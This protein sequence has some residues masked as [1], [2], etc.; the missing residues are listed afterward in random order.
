M[1]SHSDSTT[2][3]LTPARALWSGIAAILSGA[4]LIAG[5]ALTW[6]T[7]DTGD[8][9]AIVEMVRFYGD[10]GNRT[11]SETA[12]VM[13][14]ASAL[15]F[16]CFLPELVR[17]AGRRAWL[18]VAGGTVFTVCLMLA[19]ITGNVYA[20]TANHSAV[21]LVTPETSRTAILLMDV[22]Y[23]GLTAAMLGAVV[24]LIAVWRTALEG[25]GA[26]GGAAAS[27]RLWLA[28]AGLAVA[29]VSLAGPLT[30]WLT[31]MLLAVWLVAAG[32]LMVLL[33]APA[34][35]RA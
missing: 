10:E 30:A 23:G 19:A 16:L 12:A 31:P 20:I 17:A 34:G 3:P 11:L 32:L 33:K 4:L 28:W 9:G 6:R 18:A 13:M 26:A 35:P 14:L 24:M 15:L 22:A 8:Q 29:L 7:P 2:T 25:H 1:A 21:Y 5:Q 27:L